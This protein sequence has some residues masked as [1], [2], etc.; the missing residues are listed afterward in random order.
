MSVKDVT[1]GGVKISTTGIKELLQN[2]DIVKANELLGGCFS[3]SGEVVHGAGRGGE[4][5]GFPTVN[6]VY[7]ENKIKIRQGV[8]KVKSTIDGVE[9][10][11]I[12]NYGARP[13]FGEEDCVLEVNYEGF[14]GDV[15][16]QILT[17]EFVDFI[18]DIQTFDDAEQL[19]EQ[20]EKDKRCVEQTV[21][22]TTE[23]KKE[24]TVEQT[25]EQ[26]EEIINEVP[27]IQE[28]TK[29]QGES[30]S[31]GLAVTE[32]ENGQLTGQEGLEIQE[33]Q[34]VQT[35]RETQEENND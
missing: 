17:V 2:G 6:I 30:E 10:Q 12:A 20:L 24:Q 29:E 16:G 28:Q 32:E 35:E 14:D 23:Q 34:E 21:E 27:E 25:V 3:V 33:Q 4:V 19:A 1:D 5:I 31:C 13:T 7:P 26:S 22:Q 15:Y 8:Y 9:Y 11:G 18:R